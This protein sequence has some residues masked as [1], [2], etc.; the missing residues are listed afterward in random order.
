[1]VKETSIF[2]DFKKIVDS[3]TEIKDKLNAI[4]KYI[5]HEYN[6]KSYFCKIYVSRWSFFAGE[7]EINLSVKRTKISNELGFIIEDNN[8]DDKLLNN[9]VESLKTL[10]K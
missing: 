7:E 8:T 10:L 9:I 4:T 1:M 6:F 2:N 5:F 3:N